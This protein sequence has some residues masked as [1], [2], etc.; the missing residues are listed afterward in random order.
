MENDLSPS[1][2]RVIIVGGSITGLTLANMLERAGID[3]VL[4]EKREVAPQRGQSILVLP[5]TAVILEQLG[6]NK[7]LDDVSHPIR[8][9]KHFEGAERKLFHASDEPTLVFQ[10]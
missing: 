8:M 4:L 1:S 10:K 7:T 9:R 6:V 3:Y 5:S 2:F